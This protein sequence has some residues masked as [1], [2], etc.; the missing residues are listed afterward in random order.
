MRDIPP[1][2]IAEI[3]SYIDPE[4]L[5]TLSRCCFVSRAVLPVARRALYDN[6]TLHFVPSFSATLSNAVLPPVLSPRSYALEHTLLLH[7]HLAIIPHGVKL[8]DDQRRVE[9][10]SSSYNHPA[11]TIRAMWATL[12]NLDKLVIMDATVSFPTLATMVQGLVA[13]TSD[14]KDAS[15]AEVL[16]SGKHLRYLSIFEG[17]MYDYGAPLR[18]LLRSLPHLERLLVGEIFLPETE[19]HTRPTFSLS[20]LVVRSDS[21]KGRFLPFLTSSSHDSLISAALPVDSS[22]YDLSPFTRLKTVS[23]TFRCWNP[24]RKD[25]ETKKSL[26]KILAAVATAPATLK[27]VEIIENWQQNGI[28]GPPQVLTHSGLLENLPSTLE[29]VNLHGL[30]IDVSYL[31]RFLRDAP[32]GWKVLGLECRFVGE[33]GEGS[34]DEETLSKVEQACVERG[35]AVSFTGMTR[36]IRTP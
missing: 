3:I 28:S 13:N 14:S 7:P 15:S 10:P 19:D 16:P 34:N 21:S 1:E 12:P 26:K 5:H 6:I 11:H 27:R 36:A 31:L 9:T 29:S 17:G 30:Q 25:K 33:D 8:W 22:K 35:I 32:T 4:D 18:S 20:H 24:T 2:I 23:F